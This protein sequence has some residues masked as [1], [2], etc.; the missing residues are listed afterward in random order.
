[1]KFHETSEII[2]GIEKSWNFASLSTTLTTY[3]N[4]ECDEDDD[5][6]DE[7]LYANFGLKYVWVAGTFLFILQPKSL[8]N[9]DEA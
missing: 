6:D 8:F 4:N 1:M 2:P 5:D 3:L 7:A 9:F